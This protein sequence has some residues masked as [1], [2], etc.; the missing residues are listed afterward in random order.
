MSR[1]LRADYTTQL[2]FPPALE[3]WVKADDPA[4]FIRAFVDSLRRGSATITWLASLQ[5]A[6]GNSAV[7]VSS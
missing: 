7:S 2:L 5:R 1:E 6:R 4:R 3:N